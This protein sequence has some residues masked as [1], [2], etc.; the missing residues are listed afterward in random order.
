MCRGSSQADG[1]ASCLGSTYITAGVILNVFFISALIP[2]GL[3]LISYY[4]HLYLSS[5]CILAHA[6]ANSKFSDSF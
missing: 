4:M 6:T 5:G 3:S 2:C 1:H